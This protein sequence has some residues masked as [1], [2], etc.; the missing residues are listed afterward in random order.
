MSL[1]GKISAAKVTNLTSE[2]L[3]MKF[4]YY[5]VSLYDGYFIGT[6]KEDVAVD[7]SQSEDY[8]VVDAEA[9]MWLR[10]DGKREPVPD[11]SSN[12]EDS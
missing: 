9:G 12:E 4:R 6:N 3:K 7:L 8:F 1:H 2:V 11:V 5:I 10:E